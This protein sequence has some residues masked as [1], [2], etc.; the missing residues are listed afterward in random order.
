MDSGSPRSRAAEPD[1]GAPDEALARSLG[2]R[3]FAVAP[4]FLLGDEWRALA[5]EARRRHRRGAFRHAGVGRGA[6]FRIAP[7]VRD[8]AVLWI[9]PAAPARAERHWL[10]RVERLRCAL[11]QRLLLGLFGYEGHWARFEPGARYLTHLDRFADA[12]HR[13]VSLVLY[14]NEAWQPD[15]G[16][17]LR[18]YLGEPGSDPF[19]DVAPRGG[20]LAAFLSG[21]VHH[22]V[23]PATRERWSLTGWLTARRGA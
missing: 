4:G 20:T 10:E 23:L 16:G 5:R 13:L 22:E 12:S 17:A 11:N 3:G 6:S 14:L 8:D 15:E 2:E 9:D 7:E 1:P 18:L 19:T 21:E